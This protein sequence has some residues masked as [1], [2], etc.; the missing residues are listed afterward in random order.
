MYQLLCP[1]KMQGQKLPSALLPISP[2]PVSSLGSLSLMSGHVGWLLAEPQLTSPKK[3]SQL[4]IPTVVSVSETYCFQK[5]TE[6]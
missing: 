6:C 4:F 2:I 1:K 5:D 3:S